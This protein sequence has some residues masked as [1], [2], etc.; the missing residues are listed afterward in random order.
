MQSPILT[1]T[2]LV[3]LLLSALLQSIA[4][5]VDTLGS[6]SI[7]STSPP[8]EATHDDGEKSATRHH[9]QA[10][11]DTKHEGSADTL[12]KAEV[13]NWA[14]ATQTAD[15]AALDSIQQAALKD[16][17]LQ[18]Q[19]RPAQLFM[20]HTIDPDTLFNPWKVDQTSIYHVDATGLSEILRLNPFFVE[21]PFTLTSQLN[22]TL[23]MG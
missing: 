11:D 9:E 18:E 15:S 10:V 6:K 21:I 7:D 20:R 19:R 23:Y 1:T 8:I 4:A 17:I 22:R 5:Q 12:S 3:V 14:E 16:S 13:V 2:R